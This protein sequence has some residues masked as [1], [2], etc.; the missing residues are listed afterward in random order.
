MTSRGS[1]NGSGDGE[2]VGEI[3]LW[4]TFTAFCVISGGLLCPPLAFLSGLVWTAD[5]QWFARKWRIMVAVLYSVLFTGYFLMVSEIS[6]AG[7]KGSLCFSI[8]T[9]IEPILIFNGALGPILGVAILATV[10]RCRKDESVNSC[11]TCNYNLTGNVSGVCPECG[12]KIES[13]S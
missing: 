13:R 10:P 3:M 6:F 9:K 12:T 11:R 8:L 2:F 7:S 4:N 5:G 1:G